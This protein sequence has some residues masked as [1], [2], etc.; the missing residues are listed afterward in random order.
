M[1]PSIFDLGF[2]S[3]LY[4]FLI[5]ILGMG[6]WQF[7]SIRLKR[8]GE[9]EIKAR[10]LVPLGAGAT[11]IGF[12]ALVQRYREAFDMIEAADDISPSIVASAFSGAFAYPTLGLLCLAI[13]FVF[14]YLNQ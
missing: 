13:S 6:L 12:I 2:A 3:I 10:S 5:Y 7:K 1:L 4:L 9:E 14:K 11:V 8:D